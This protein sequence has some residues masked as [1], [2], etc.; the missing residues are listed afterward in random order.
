M[1]KNY[2]VR[3]N[4]Y[5]QNIWGIKQYFINTF[6][7]DPPTVNGYKMTLHRNESSGPATMNFK[8]NKTLEKEKHHLAREHTT[9]F[10]QIASNPNVFLSS[11]ICF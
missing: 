4:D 6:G 10:S 2:F 7:N 8:N 11:Q 9:A 3:L 5:L 1:E